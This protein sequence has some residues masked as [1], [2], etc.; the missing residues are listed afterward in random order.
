MYLWFADARVVMRDIQPE[1]RSS[2]D[3][4][5]AHAG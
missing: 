3:V 1:R 5:F 2:H 4:L